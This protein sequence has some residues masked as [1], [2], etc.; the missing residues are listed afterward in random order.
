MVRM[1]TGNVQDIRD[2]DIIEESD[3]PICT[4]GP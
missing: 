1:F 3:G 2:T 4:I